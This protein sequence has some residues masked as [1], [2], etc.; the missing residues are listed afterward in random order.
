MSDVNEVG[1]VEFMRKSKKSERAVKRYV[2]YMKTFEEYLTKHGKNL[3]VVTPDDLRDFVDWGRR[4]SLKVPQYLWAIRTYYEYIPDESLFN[5]TREL[6]GILYMET[7]RLKDFRRVRTKIVEKLALKGIKAAKQMLDAG[8]SKNER[9]KLAEETGIQVEHILEL[10]KLSNLA[11]IPG[12]KQV[13]AR[14]YYDAGL[15]TLEK[16]AE[17]DPEEMREML[18]QFIEKNNF[19]GSPPLPKEAVMTVTLARHLPKLV[20]Y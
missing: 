2:N 1:F 3:E 7:Y 18:K 14:L 13:R 5:T 10:V 20:E 8:K 19:D 12:V 16:I 6:I 4:R 17:L 9:E 11:R 15:D